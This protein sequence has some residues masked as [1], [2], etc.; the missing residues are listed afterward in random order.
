MLIRVTIAKT[1]NLMFARVGIL[2]VT[3]RDPDICKGGD[4]DWQVGIL[5][6][7]IVGTLTVIGILTDNGIDSDSGE[8]RIL[9]VI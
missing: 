2:T 8:A 4:S 9:T 3:S 6:V 5:T 1:G 7:A